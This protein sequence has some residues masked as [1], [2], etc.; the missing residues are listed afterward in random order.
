[1]GLGHS[2]REFARL[3]WFR[4][5]GVLDWAL[6]E[7]AKTG[8]C[9]DSK[10]GCHQ[11]SFVIASLVGLA[12][13]AVDG[14]R[15]LWRSSGSWIG[16][17]QC[18]GRH[19][20]QVWRQLQLLWWVFAYEFD[21]KSPKPAVELWPHDLTLAYDQRTARTA[22]EPRSNY[23]M[24]V[25]QTEYGPQVLPA[26]PL[27]HPHDALLR[28]G[29]GFPISAGGTAAHFEVGALTPAAGEHE[30]F[31]DARASAV[32]EAVIRFDRGPVLESCL[33]EAVDDG[34][35]AR[36][37]LRPAAGEPEAS[38]GSCDRMLIELP[39]R[40][41]GVEVGPNGGALTPAA[42]EPG[43]GAHSWRVYELVSRFEGSRE[44]QAGFLEAAIASE[45]RAR[46]AILTIHH[47]LTI[48]LPLVV[49]HGTVGRFQGQ[50]TERLLA[51]LSLVL[52]GSRTLGNL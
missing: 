43:A 31:G 40:R 15:D 50:I 9:E 48:S 4:G 2:T 13:A 41:G 1:M 34:G 5:R 35:G 28:L 36:D 7:F 42:G 49:L 46:D 18:P 11:M 14:G 26:P 8:P 17:A 38:P 29:P 12:Y 51:A 21:V 32:H 10:E 23:H 47:L 45:N 37:A 6:G 16:I 30:E 44:L 25:P 22:P 52:D 3:D 33:T 39:S 24:T 27:L 20:P 19:P